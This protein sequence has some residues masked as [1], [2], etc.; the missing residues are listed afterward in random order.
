MADINLI[1]RAKRLLIGKGILM[2]A[3]II[4]FVR[5]INRFHGI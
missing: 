3:L 1:F 5:I 2:I 4:R